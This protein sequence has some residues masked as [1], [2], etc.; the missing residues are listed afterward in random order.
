MLID[1]HRHIG[2]SGVPGGVD[3]GDVFDHQRL[4]PRTA[5]EK[6]KEDARE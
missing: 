3:H 2:L 6:G 4:R 5:A 1:D